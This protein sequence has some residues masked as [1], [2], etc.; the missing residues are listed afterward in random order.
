[1]KISSRKYLSI[2]KT[3]LVS[4]PHPISPPVRRVAHDISE[5]LR[6]AACEQFPSA[7]LPAPKPR[8]G[9]ELGSAAL[10][11]G[12]PAKVELVEPNHSVLPLDSHWSWACWQ[13]IVSK[14]RT[15]ELAEVDAA[16]LTDDLPPAAFA[17]SGFVQFLKV[18][19]SDSSK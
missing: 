12:P 9:D 13:S 19:Q 4:K 6:S 5:R 8:S 18:R 1:M 16:L 14:R 10:T 7:R 15:Q 3:D 11:W 2:C 17:D